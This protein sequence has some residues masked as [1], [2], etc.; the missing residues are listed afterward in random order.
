MRLFKLLAIVGLFTLASC[1]QVESN[2]S[3]E[4][5]D[6]LSIDSVAVSDVSVTAD[7]VVQDSL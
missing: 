5:T 6:T 3:T 1:A 2:D 7:S 4:V